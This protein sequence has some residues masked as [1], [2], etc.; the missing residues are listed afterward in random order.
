[1]PLYDL[2]HAYFF[3]GERVH[4]D[5]TRC[6]LTQKAR[7][8]GSK[9]A[10]G[11]GIPNCRSLV[12]TK[13]PVQQLCKPNFEGRWAPEVTCTRF[14]GPII[15]GK[16]QLSGMSDSGHWTGKD[17]EEIEVHGSVRARPGRWTSSTI[18]SRPGANRVYSRSS[19]RSRGST[20]RS[21]RSSTF[22]AGMLWRCWNGSATSWIPERIPGGSRNRVRVARPGPLDV[23]A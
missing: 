22:V 10:V 16:F 8:P 7:W 11:L 1:V 20:R 3:A 17:H 4:G 19:M 14:S 12:G 21:S 15:A 23:S 6:R 2:A 18:S 5:H 9:N 13:R